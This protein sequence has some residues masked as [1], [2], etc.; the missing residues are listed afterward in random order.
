MA[1]WSCS[2]LQIRER[3]F[4]SDLGLH[5]YI[6]IFSPDGEIG[7]RKGLKISNVNR[8]EEVA[9]WLEP[10]QNAGSSRIELSRLD[11]ERLAR[12]QI[13][14]TRTKE[15]VVS[16]VQAGQNEDH[17]RVVKLVDT[18]DLNNLSPPGE[19]LKVKPVKLGESP[20][21]ILNPSQRRAKPQGNFLGK[22]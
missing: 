12:C 2:G 16:L 11:W 14:A 6:C 3:R 10:R 13:G 9:M 19:T 7:R 5:L 4:D 21:F 20:G 22:V 15:D 1:E 8:F 18:R 17:A